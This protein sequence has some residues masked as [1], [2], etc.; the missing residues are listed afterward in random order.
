MLLETKEEQGD[1]LILADIEGVEN[2]YVR[3]LEEYP[4]ILEKF[5]IL[6]EIFLRVQRCL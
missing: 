3:Y 1:N 2:K 6:K 5:Q 4:N